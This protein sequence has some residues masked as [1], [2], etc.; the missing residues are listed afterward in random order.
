M[1]GPL[2][3]AELFP[4]LARRNPSNGNLGET[5]QADAVKLICI[6]QNLSDRRA[7]LAHS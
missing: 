3:K 6:S 7:R 1:P 2:N 4:Q 5:Y